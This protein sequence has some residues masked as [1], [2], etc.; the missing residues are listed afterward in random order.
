M[1]YTQAP[2]APAEVDPTHRLVDAATRAHPHAH[3]RNAREA[4][5]WIRVEGEGSGKIHLRLGDLMRT[6]AVR[7]QN[8]ADGDT[9]TRLCTH[10]ETL[11]VCNRGYKCRFVHRV[12]THPMMNADGPAHSASRRPSSTAEAKLP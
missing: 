9:V 8:L 11:G 4:R 10:F 1:P 6:R 12:A 7:A 3:G 5:R 2:C